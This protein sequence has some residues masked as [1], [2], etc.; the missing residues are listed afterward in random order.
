M[1]DVTQIRRSITL[2]AAALIGAVTTIMLLCATAL[3][4]RFGGDDDGTWGAA[5]V[6]D[7]LKAAVARDE[8]GHLIVRTTPRLAKVIREFPTFWY[9]ISDQNGEIRYGPVPKW[10]P[11]KSQPQQDGPNF[12]AYEIDG[13]ERHLKKMLAF[14]RT[15][16]GEIWIETGGV[17]YTATHN[18]NVA[19]RQTP[20][21][22]TTFELSF[23]SQCDQAKRPRREGAL[24]EPDPRTRWKLL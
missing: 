7:A 20:G 15:P 18:G 8:Q 21:G 13:N 16:V 22:G 6:S 3:L 9:V 10:R 5:D 23:P 17:A 1:V 2:L 11:Q 19:I 12:L 24:T 14:T 4:I